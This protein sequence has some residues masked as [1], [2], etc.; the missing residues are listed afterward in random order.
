M[1][2]CASKRFAGKVTSPPLEIQLILHV[3][4]LQQFHILLCIAMYSFPWLYMYL[5]PKRVEDMRFYHLVHDSRDFLDLKLLPLQ[6]C[7]LH[8]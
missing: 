5:L 1:T 7:L 2:E 3:E 4:L 6:G 8:R